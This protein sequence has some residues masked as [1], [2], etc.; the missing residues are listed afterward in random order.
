MV[1][2]QLGNRT[3]RFSNEIRTRNDTKKTGNEW[4]RSRVL[5]LHLNP[6]H[7]YMLQTIADTRGYGLAPTL[8]MLIVEAYERREGKPYGD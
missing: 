8:R 1:E 6:K 3:D 2:T 4:T 5:H 7:S